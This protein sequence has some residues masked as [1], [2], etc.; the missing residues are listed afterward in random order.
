MAQIKY[1]CSLCLALTGL[2]TGCY[3]PIALSKA[4]LTAQAEQELKQAQTQSLS[5][6]SATNSELTL[7]VE[8]AMEL[9][10][11][12]STAIK[13]RQASVA[14]SQARIAEAGQLR[15]P[16]IRYS[17]E[18]LENGFGDGS[19]M[20]VEFRVRPPRPGEIGAQKSI[21]RASKRAAEAALSREKNRVKSRV[22]TLFR[23]IGFV[24]A[25][26]EASKESL[27]KRKQ[28][29]ELARLRTQRALGTQIDVA[30][31]EVTFHE[32]KQDLTELQGEYDLLS[33]ELLRLI[34]LPQEIKLTLKQKPLNELKVEALE[35]LQVYVAQALENRL[36][37]D[38]AAS[39]IDAARAQTFMEK[40]QAWPWFSHIKVGYEMRPDDSFDGAITGGVALEIPLFSLNGG[41]IEEAETRESLRRSEYELEVEDIIAQVQNQYREV[42][43]AA[44]ALITL[45]DGSKV[46]AEAAAEAAKT[47]M[48]AGQVVVQEL[49][50]IEERAASTHRQWLKALRRY[51]REHTQLLQR[52]APAQ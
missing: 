25:E 38:I 33:K 10:Q 40:T 39:R 22:R 15:N 12:S 41:G 13:V 29:V 30:L 26:I 47:A 27:E 16:E 45:R 50:L 49:A 4:D 34:G 23:E 3:S 14:L 18:K 2:L 17:Q 8:K 9:A 42:Q 5:T 48:K 37:L 11:Q 24:E 36:E 52:I 19:R 43:R 6:L 35:P 51:H 32:A 20:D 44:E 1:L 31:A 46:A 21:A 28:L 7:S